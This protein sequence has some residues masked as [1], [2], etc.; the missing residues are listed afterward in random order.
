[1]ARSA[2]TITDV[3]QNAD[4]TLTADAFD[5]TNNHSI[6]VSDTS[7]VEL[8]VIIETLDTKAAVFDIKAGDG[9]A[10]D[11]GDLSITTGAAGK[12]IFSLDSA[13]FKDNDGLILID[14]TSAASATGNIY[15]LV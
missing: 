14:I 7:C 1:M 15:A 5:I 6:D 3:S 12:H 4:N 11:Q 13:R 2:I 8:K 9:Q 10:A